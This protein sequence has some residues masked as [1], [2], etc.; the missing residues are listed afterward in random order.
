ML[1]NVLDIE[2]RRVDHT[3]RKEFPSAMTKDRLRRMIYFYDL[4]NQIKHINGDIVE[5]GVGW[6]SSLFYFSVCAGL[7]DKKRHL[8]GFDAFEKGFPE[9]S[10]ED[11]PSLIRKGE[12]SK[13]E[14]SVRRFL[15][16]GRISQDFISD[17]ITF[18]NGFF[19]KTLA[20]YSGEEIALLHLD[21]DHYQSYKD[22][23]EIL[24]SKVVKGGI[25]AFDEYHQPTRYPGAK[26]SIDEFLEDSKE[27]IIKSS[28]IDR[29]YL[30]KSS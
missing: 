7:F 21:I 17:H 16:R 12:K 15:I 23:L 26:K 6:G 20:G 3:N 24:Y 2:I 22:C 25:I 5:C 28:I 18:V 29:Y 30:V 19:D 27:T 13:T 14:D 4:Q 9:P 8:Y 11:Q 10:K 1:R